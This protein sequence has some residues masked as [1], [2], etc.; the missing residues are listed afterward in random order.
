VGFGGVKE[1]TLYCGGG[2]VYDRGVH[3]GYDM[4]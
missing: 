3:S 4:G 2:A 1:T